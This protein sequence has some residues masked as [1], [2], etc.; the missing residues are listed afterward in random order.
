MPDDRSQRGKPDRIRI[1]IHEAYELNYWAGKW[2]VSHQAII[3]AV[4]AVGVMANDV[5]AYLRSKRLI[6]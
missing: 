6:S 4:Q 3:S 5:E 1:N 2:G